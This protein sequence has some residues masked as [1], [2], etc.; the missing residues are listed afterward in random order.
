MGKKRLV[1]VDGAENR[2]EEAGTWATLSG[3]GEAKGGISLGWKVPTFSLLTFFNA[4]NK[5]LSSEPGS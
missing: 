4:F 2:T 1:Y 5:M 3:P